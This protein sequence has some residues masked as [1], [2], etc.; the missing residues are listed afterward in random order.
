MYKRGTIKVYKKW[1][2]IWLNVTYKKLIIIKKGSG[3]SINHYFQIKMLLLHFIEIFLWKKIFFFVSLFFNYYLAM[4][5]LSI[6]KILLH[7]FCLQRF[8]FVIALHCSAKNEMLRCVY[9]KKTID[10]KR[11]SHR[12]IISTFCACP[13][14]LL[15]CFTY[16]ISFEW[17][18]NIIR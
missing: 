8:F 6:I 14:L 12:A 16:T 7:F 4:L 17:K 2:I 11:T 5:L 1:C 10:T 15:L 18:G 13:L 9:K 3:V